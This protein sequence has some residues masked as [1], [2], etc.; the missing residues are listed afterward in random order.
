MT[1]SEYARLPL[2][3]QDPSSL[4][5]AYQKSG[6]V[7]DG[8]PGREPSQVRTGQDRSLGPL[9]VSQEKPRDLVDHL[10]DGAG[11]DG[12]EH[13][14]Q[15]VGE[16]EAPDPGPQNG[17][18][19]PEQRQPEEVRKSWPLPQDGRGNA[20]A[21]GDVVQGKPYDQEDAQRGLPEGEGRPDGE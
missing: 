1:I 3:A 18:T 21:F 6:R 10:Q 9:R 15:K 8:D 20:D 12:Q 7:H 14:R 5:H 19:S 13:G 4:L 16:G 11:T 17:G 2:P